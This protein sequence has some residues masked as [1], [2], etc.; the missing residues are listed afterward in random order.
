MQGKRREEC[1]CFRD[2]CKIKDVSSL[3]VENRTFG[4]VRGIGKPEKE[5]P[6]GAKRSLKDFFLKFVGLLQM[7]TFKFETLCTLNIYTM[8]KYCNI[9]NIE[10]LKIKILKYCKY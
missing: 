1:K 2:L 4:A 7:L 3:N 8:L 10:M 9:L 5:N 6:S